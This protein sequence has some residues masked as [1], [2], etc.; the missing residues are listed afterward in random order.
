MFARLVN[1]FGAGSQSVEGEKR[2]HAW[3]IR[4]LWAFRQLSNLRLR[5]ELG[6]W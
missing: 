1:A 4:V 6:L 2:G 3:R 5:S